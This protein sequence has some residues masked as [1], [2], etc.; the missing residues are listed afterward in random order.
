MFCTTVEPGKQRVFLEHD[1]AV[2]AGPGHRLAEHLDA[3][4]VGRE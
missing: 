4:V 1:A 3:A 2:D